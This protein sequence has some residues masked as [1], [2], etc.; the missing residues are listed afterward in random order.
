MG[1]FNAKIG[2]REENATVGNYGLGERN[3]KGDRLVQFCAENQLIVANIFFEQHPRCLYT[4]KS[5]ADGTRNIVRNQIDFILIHRNYRKHLKS[6]KT[7]PGADI[8]SDHNSVVIKMTIRRCFKK[9]KQ[10]DGKR[11]DVN[12]LKNKF[13][14]AEVAENLRSKLSTLR[15]PKWNEV[16]GIISQTQEQRIGKVKTSRKNNWITEEIL[17]KMEERRLVKDKRKNKEVRKMCREAKEKFYRDKCEKIEEL[18]QRRDFF[19]LHKRVKKTA[20]VFRKTITGLLRDNTR[21]VIA[22]KEDRLRQWK[23]YIGQ[24]FEDERSPEIPEEYPENCEEGPPITKYE[25][26]HAK[27]KQHDGKAV[28]PD[29]IHSEVLKVIAESLIKE[30]E[31]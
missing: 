14:R 10:Q 17:D 21:K 13:F 28:G 29:E 6:A 12:K 30:S 24:L 18:Q 31:K 9:V 8:N 19:N 3:E 2:K 11:I 20:G 7:Y 4:W 25:V 1:D 23:E 26:K 27:Q 16:K 5:P 22:T 15:D